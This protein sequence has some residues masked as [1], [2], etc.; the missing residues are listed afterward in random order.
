MKKADYSIATPE[1][2]EGVVEILQRNVNLIIEQKKTKNPKRLRQIVSGLC[3]RVRSGDV[4]T[5]KD[6]QTLVQLFQKKS[7]V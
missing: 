3:E 7:V 1:E 2:R 4:I 6:F 5:G